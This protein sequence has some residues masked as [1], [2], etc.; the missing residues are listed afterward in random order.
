VEDQRDQ[1]IPEVRLI[2]IEEELAGFYLT[3][4]ISKYGEYHP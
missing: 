1:L 3:E 2:A 4:V